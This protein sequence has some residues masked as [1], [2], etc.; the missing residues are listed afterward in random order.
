MSDTFLKPIDFVEVAATP[1]NPPAGYRRIYSKS[2]GF[3]YQLTS[4]GVETRLDNVASGGNLLVQDEG[5]TLTTA[6]T[7]LNFT[8]GGVTATNT[9]GDVTINVPANQ[10]AFAA[11]TGDTGTAT[12]D[13]QSDSVAI[14]GTNGISTTATDTPDGLVI[15]PTYGTPGTIQ[16]DDAASAGAANSFARSDHIHAITTAAPT[17]IGTTNTEGAATSFARS[18]HVHSHGA[19]TDAAHHAVATT[20]ANGFMSATDKTKLDGV[21]TGAQVNQNAFSVVTGN[22]GTSTSDVQSDT[23]AITGSNGISTASTDS[24]DGLVISPT[25]G[26]PTGLAPDGANTAGVANSFA[27]SDH[28]HAT[29]TDVPVA[30]GA[31]A[32][33]GVSASFARADHVHVDPVIAHL[34][35][36]DPHPQYTTTAEVTAVL[37]NVFSTIAVSGQSN[38]VADTTTDTLTLVAGTNVTITTDAGADS[39]TINA[40][41]GGG[42]SGLDQPNVLARISLRI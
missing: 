41:G 12:A 17:T 31:A 42:G 4:A 34:A 9:A 21:A 35:A 8:G 37:P 16:P 25:Y 11:I 36:G 18:D 19:Q 29:P 33:E 3:T 39:I 22:T 7:S 20:G 40:T 28:I 23:L 13:T 26:S 30:L 5:S 1:S 2:D 27:R 14:T 10:N 38:V 6:A 15:S 24:P 32:S